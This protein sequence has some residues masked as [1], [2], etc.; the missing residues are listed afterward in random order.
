MSF[1]AVVLA[2]GK[3]T[4]LS[5]FTYVLP[6]PLLPVSQRPIL[7][8]VLTQLA[9]HGC[10]HVT[11]AVGHLGHLIEVYCGT[12]DRWGLRID[13]FREEAP[14]GTVGALAQI[15]ELPDDPFI[16]M[17]GDVLSDIDYGDLLDFHGRSG[18]ELTIAA[19]R[20]TEQDELGIIEADSGGRVTAYREKP[21][22]EYLV[23]MGIYVLERSVL[24][25]IPP[26]RMDFPELVEALLGDQRHVNT[27]VHA[28]YWL[29]L[30]RPDDFGRANEEF[31]SIR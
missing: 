8:I 28:D 20:R 6:K 18:A 1:A 24:D 30:G 19:F 10:T 15:E 2:G 21:Q 22:H 5:P 26:D 13:Y 29:D 14:L 12:G 16:V 27:H 31:E 11:L 25:L 4:R 3:G 23:S 17:N 9:A 7:D